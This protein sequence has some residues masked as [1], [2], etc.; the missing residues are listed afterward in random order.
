MLERHTLRVKFL[1]GILPVFAVLGLI[2]VIAWPILVDI[3]ENVRAAQGALA[4][5][6]EE[7]SLAM[8]SAG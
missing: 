7:V 3:R 1:R 4:L 5:T 8:P 2:G 6:A